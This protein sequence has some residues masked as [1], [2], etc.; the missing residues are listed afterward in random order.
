MQKTVNDSGAGITTRIVRFKPEQRGL[1]LLLAGF[2]LAAAATGFCESQRA[3]IPDDPLAV[4]AL[5]AQSQSDATGIIQEL[6]NEKA[7]T[8]GTVRLPPGRF[9]IAGQLNIPEAVTLEGSWED[10]VHYL[11]TAKNTVLLITGRK[12]SEDFEG[13]GAIHLNGS[14]GLKGMTIV[15]PE[16]EFPGVVPYPW[17]ITGDG[18]SIHIE[19]ITLINSYQGIRLGL[20]DSSLHYVRNVFGTVLRRGLWV[21]NCWDIG[22]VENV[23]F[24]CHYWARTKL[25]RSLPDLLPNVDQVV[26]NYTREH[27]EAFIINKNDWGMLKD[28]FVYGARTGYL[29]PAKDHGGFNGRMIGSGADGCITCI[30]IENS[31]P[32]GIQ[33]LGG[34]F[35]SH[36]NF[37]P[38][39][40]LRIDKESDVIPNII[41]T[42]GSSDGPVQFS[43][44][45][46]FGAPVHIALLQGKG[47]ITFNQCLF[48]GWDV[49]NTGAEAIR[50]LNGKLSVSDSQFLEWPGTRLNS[51]YLGESVASA[52]IIGNLS[53][54]ETR[55]NSQIGERA[56]IDSND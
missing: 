3:A 6:V 18:Y 16:Q 25:F 22:R 30:R 13:K 50:A 33:I 4:L 28:T 51:V 27:L 55:I 24:N 2:A 31:N 5:A 1:R 19:N 15:Y 21:D 37:K 36:A 23:H 54:S 53:S 26:A 11:T 7:K 56:V 20:S 34:T 12:G 52:K 44:C 9:L 43:N 32:Y 42:T 35:V 39:K 10:T 40:G 49:K 17:T 48:R 38:E 8:G 29:F 41:E 14:S 46:F 47:F 45:S